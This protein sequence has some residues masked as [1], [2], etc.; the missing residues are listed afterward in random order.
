MIT[1]DCVF[2]WGVGGEQHGATKL[3]MAGLTKIQQIAD[4]C[5]RRLPQEFLWNT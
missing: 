3:A 5:F 1:N 4:V 2:F